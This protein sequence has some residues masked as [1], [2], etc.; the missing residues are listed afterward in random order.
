MSSSDLAAFKAK[1]QTLN[2]VQWPATPLFESFWV[3]ELKASAEQ[4]WKA[5]AD[6]SRFNRSLGLAPRSESIQDGKTIVTTT[7]LGQR[8][9]WIEDPW[10][11]VAQQSIDSRRRYLQGIARSVHAFFYVEEDP[12]G[13]RRRVFIYFGWQPTSLL[14]KL[15]LKSTDSLLRKKFAANFA[16]IDTHAASAANF[17]P[18]RRAPIPLEP[19]ALTT[20]EG[21]RTALKARDVDAQLVERLCTHIVESDRDEIGSIRVRQIAREWHVEPDALLKVCL[22]AASLGLLRISWKVLCPHCRAAQVSADSIGDIPETSGCPSCE[23]DFSTDAEDSI[24]V[25]FHVHPSIRDVS[26]VSFCAAEPDKKSHIKVQRWVEAHTSS[27][28]SPSLERGRYRIRAIGSDASYDFEV[29]TTAS[30]PLSLKNTDAQARLFVVEKLQWDPDILKP[31]HVFAVN[32]FRELFSHEHLNS[33]VKIY[34]G[35]QTILFTD[36]VGSTKFYRSIGDAKAFAA[37]RSHFEEVTTEIKSHKGVVVKTIG[38]AV[39]ASF[40]VRSKALDCAAAIL[41]RFHHDREDTPI[42]LRASVHAGPV[43]AVQLNNGLDYFGTTV[44][45]AA[46][47]QSYAGDGEIAMSD[48]LFSLLSGTPVEHRRLDFERRERDHELIGSAPVYVVKVLPQAE[49]LITIP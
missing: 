1:T 22:H 43:I 29:A 4:I 7:L 35:E 8:Q 39:M 33:K 27:N 19:E 31:S 44:N 20:L 32:E 25:T 30:V 9:V 24:E 18:L 14:A 48:E 26:E 2:L 47:I 11:W 46:K 15:F 23:I 10:T 49:K 34:L 45:Y 6:S 36:I 28:L 17:A 16:E 37:V 12:A 38:D 41:R 42:R 13:D 40:S 5:L 21:Y 3:F